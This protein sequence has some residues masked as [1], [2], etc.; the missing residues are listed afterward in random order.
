[1][2]KQTNLTTNLQKLSEIADWFDQQESV[3]IEEGLVKV[4]AAAVLIKES[5]QRLQAI[6]NEFIEIKK[7]IEEE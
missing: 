1:M 4:K 5:K 6:E 2:S 7:S 3:D